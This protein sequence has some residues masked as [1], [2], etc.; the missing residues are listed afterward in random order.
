MQRGCIGGDAA[1][2]QCGV[3]AGMRC[4]FGGGDAAGM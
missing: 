2:I 3:V 4:E 1:G